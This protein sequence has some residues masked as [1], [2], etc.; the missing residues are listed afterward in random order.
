MIYIWLNAPAILLATLAGLLLAFLFYR[1]AGIAWRPS[2]TLLVTALLAHGWLAAILA[3]AL[4]LAPPEA[5]PLVMA[6]LTPV[7]IWAGFSLPLLALSAQVRGLGL[8][9]GLVESLH[10]VLV[11]LA[12]AVVLIAVGLTPPPG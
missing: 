9:A 4:I 8:K 10:W 6:L 12:Q 1:V 11:M 2:A 5:P 7:V 3:G